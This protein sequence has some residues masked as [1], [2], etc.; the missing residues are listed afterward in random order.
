MSKPY[1]IT[2]TSMQNKVVL[3]SCVFNKLF[4]QETDREQAI[5]LIKELSKRK[6]QVIVPSL[7]L[8]EVL[9][10]ASVN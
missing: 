2:K 8:Y 1:L 6:Y 4:L 5:A 9:T 10:I 3:D 7:F